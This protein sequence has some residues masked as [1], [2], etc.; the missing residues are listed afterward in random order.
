MSAKEK[1]GKAKWNIN[2][3]YIYYDISVQAFQKGLRLGTHLNKKGCK[4]VI[5]TFKK[6]SGINFEKSQLKNK[7]D[8][9]KKEWRLWKELIGKE[10][11]LGWDANKQTIDATDEWWEEK[12]KVSSNIIF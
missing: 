8:T 2:L 1:Q 6:Q 11:G 3:L 9:Q 12:I 7:W 4:Y 5:E 10:N